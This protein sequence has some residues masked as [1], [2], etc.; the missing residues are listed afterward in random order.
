MHR[1]TAATATDAHREG[2]HASAH[3]DDRGFWVRAGCE[4]CALTHDEDG[5]PVFNEDTWAASPEHALAALRV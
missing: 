4:L 2:R 3:P 1:P 5:Q